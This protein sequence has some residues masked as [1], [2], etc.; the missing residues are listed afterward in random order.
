MDI[1]YQKIVQNT[2]HTINRYT[3]KSPYIEI[4][5]D[6]PASD[7]DITSTVYVFSSYKYSL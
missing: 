7:F 6:I 1:K 5:F 3:G 4:K 2:H